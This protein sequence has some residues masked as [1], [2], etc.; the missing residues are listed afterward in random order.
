M[1]LTFDRIEQRTLMHSLLLG[2]LANENETTSPNLPTRSFSIEEARDPVTG[3]P[4][5]SHLKFNAG[6]VS[7]I[8]LDSSY[9]YLDRSYGQQVLSESLRALISTDWG[10]VTD[11][12]NLGRR[13]PPPLFMAQY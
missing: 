7:V 11:R 1:V 3:G 4:G 2:M 10:T 9:P 8:D 13:F 6:S 12:I 5:M